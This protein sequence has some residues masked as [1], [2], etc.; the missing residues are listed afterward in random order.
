MAEPESQ[1]ARLRA[2]IESSGQVVGNVAG[3]AVGLVTGP[4]FA[5]GAGVA[6]GEA[7]ARVGVEFYDRVLAPR[8]VA[9]AGG[10]LGAAVMRIGERLEAGDELRDD[11]F[12]DVGPEGRAEADEVLEGTMMTAANAW[13]ERKVEP[14]GRL[15]ANLAFDDSISPGWANFLLRVAD[16]LTYNQM[17]LLEFVHQADRP[18]P[19]QSAVTGLSSSASAI[20]VAPDMTFYA[21]LDG[22][23]MA[24]LV[25][26]RRRS[27][28][29]VPPSETLGGGAWSPNR[30]VDADLMPAGRALHDLMELDLL[31]RDDLDRVLV[32]LRGDRDP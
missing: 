1:P 25:G 5:T 12:F 11:G 10:A 29:A 28:P 20:R 30:L 22:L 18:G 16:G 27:G 21:Q 26:L 23:S 17:L 15:Y 4:V 6:M 14:L 13:E 19:Y 8:Q 31:P 24:R 7:L 9:R 2:L 3:V 32:G